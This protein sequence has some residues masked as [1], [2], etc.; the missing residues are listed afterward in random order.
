MMET[1]RELPQ[2]LASEQSVLG[3]LML[4]PRALPR[5]ADWLAEDDFFHRGHRLIYRAILSLA[6]K[7]KPVDAVTMG[8]WFEAQAL[9]GEIGGSGYL[10]QLASST[11]SA[12]N[13][14]AYAEIVVEKARLRQAI[15][16][17]ESLVEKG[18]SRGT[19]AADLSAYVQQG[20][21][22]L[23]PVRHTGLLP[24]KDG[25]RRWWDEVMA[26]TDR[27]GLIG[28]PTPWADL[29]TATK[30]LRPGRLYVLAGRPGMGKSILGGQV[31]MFTALRGTRTALF[32]LEMSAEEI[33]QRNASA[34]SGVPH[35]FLESPVT[36]ST[37]WSALNCAIG[38]LSK[39]PLLV[40]DTPGLSAAQVA[41][42]AERAHLQS[43]LGLIVVDHLHE[44]S[45]DAKDRVNALGDAARRLKGLAKH[46]NVPMLLLAQLNRGAASREEKRPT[47]T[48]LRASGSIEEVA[49]AIFFIH[50]EDYYRPNT[51]LRD[52]V[53]IHI[54]K[55]RNI[56]SGVTI[57]LLNSYHCM[58]ADDWK[59]PLPEAQQPV[60]ANGRGFD[61]RR[62]AGGRDA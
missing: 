43:G 49:D 51:H 60:V 52:V 54:A 56:R 8:E 18:F 50:R 17:G 9:A 61:G 29:N 20:L 13:V 42:R 19:T 5:V 38:E 6:E 1:E 48:D 27:P 23:T 37:H 4:E 39:A 58:R 31:A 44:M 59:G 62:A 45:V 46:L 2:S 3:G 22:G 10:I 53:E 21:S 28:L 16:L 11:P 41:A 12:A 40:D 14:V 7:G 33:H 24:A 26:R 36:D 25:L 35:D 30:G 15:D 34:L 47:M 57:N 32:S 55:G